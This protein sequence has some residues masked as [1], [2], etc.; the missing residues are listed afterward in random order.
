MARGSIRHIRRAKLGSG[1]GPAARSGR[2]PWPPRA[3]A[4]GDPEHQVAL[5]GGGR[6]S[7]CDVFALV[8]N[9][10][11]TLAV[12]IKAKVREPFARFCPFG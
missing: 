9:D 6:P 2:D 3:I 10:A 5:P 12:A 11:G 7:Q 8:R 4:A 1:K